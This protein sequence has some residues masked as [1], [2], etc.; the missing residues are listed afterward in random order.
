MYFPTMHTFSFIDFSLKINTQLIVNDYFANTTTTILKY[1]KY[2]RSLAK[3]QNVW[4]D[5]R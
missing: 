2:I 1:Y 5:N 3:D 4:Y